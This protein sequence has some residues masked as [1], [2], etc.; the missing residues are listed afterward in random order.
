MGWMTGI[1]IGNLDVAK[2]IC[3]GTIHFNMELK[4]S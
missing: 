1:D 4:R 2:G 3:Y